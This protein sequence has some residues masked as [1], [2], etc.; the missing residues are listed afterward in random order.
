MKISFQKHFSQEG[1]VYSQRISMTLEEFNALKL[2]FYA[3]IQKGLPRKSEYIFTSGYEIFM[4]MI[5]KNKN[6]L[7]YMNNTQKKFANIFLKLP[8]KDR[9]TYLLINK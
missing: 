9:N 8:L 2:A 6:N 1:T 7:C 3:E 4:K 5:V